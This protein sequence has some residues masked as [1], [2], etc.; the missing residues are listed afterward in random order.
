M[1]VTYKKHWNLLDKRHMSKAALRKASGIAPN[2]MTKLRRDEPVELNILDKICAV[3][4][5][6][7]GDIILSDENRR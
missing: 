4:D 5:C 1:A 6:N 2:I 3:L 7:Y